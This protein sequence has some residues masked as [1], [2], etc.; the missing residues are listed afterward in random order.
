LPIPA[1]GLVC[2]SSDYR[3]VGVMH[4]HHVDVWSLRLDV[5]AKAC[6]NGT[7]TPS[8]NAKKKRKN[9]NADEYV[10]AEQSGSANGGPDSCTLALRIALQGTEHIHTFAISPCGR[11]IAVSGHFG[12]RLWSLVKNS[13]TKNA[14]TQPFICTKIEV[15]EFAEAFAHALCFSSTTAGEGGRL[16]VCTDQG[17]ISILNLTENKVTK[18]C[19]VSVWH[20]F[21]HSRTMREKH[22]QDTPSQSHDDVTSSLKR[23]VQELVLSSDGLYLAVRDCVNGVYVYEID[24]LRLY[25]KLPA[26]SSVVTSIAF[27]PHS[28]SQLVVLTAENVLAFDLN[29]MALTAWSEINSEKIQNL[30]CKTS[31]PLS[32]V[33]F[34]PNSPHRLFV[35]GQG[36]CVHIDT[37]AVVPKRVK[38]VM[39]SIPMSGYESDGLTATTN[40]TTNGHANG[41]AR[42][43]KYKVEGGDS[44]NFS[45]VYAYRSVIDM[46]F[47]DKQLVRTCLLL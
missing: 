40:M 46:G 18:A 1:K 6:I 13:N 14:K 22:K 17:K 34:D 16:T 33:V 27:S 12:C 7:S 39:P 25:W 41:S 38:V 29:C 31:S 4:Q 3:V 37:S 15:P 30:L 11:F 9:E 28:A 24:R 19:A 20:T 35:H 44:S 26:I 43:K 10:D 42:K 21:D 32:G 23:A 2:K 8:K 36:M 47:L 45:T 5:P